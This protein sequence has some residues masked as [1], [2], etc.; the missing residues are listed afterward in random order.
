MP[1]RSLNRDF[2]SA[3]ALGKY[4]GYKNVTKFGRNPAA[5]AAM[6]DVTYQSGILDWRESATTIEAISSDADDID[7]TGAGARKIMVEGLDANFNEISEEIAMNG[8]D[9]TS[10]TSASFLRVNRA[11]VSDAGVYANG[12]TGSNEGTI[13]IRVASAGAT[14]LQIG[15][16]GTIG[17]GQT[18]HAGYT[19]PAGKSV[20]LYHAWINVDGAQSASVFLWKRENA[21]DVSA[22]FSARRLQLSL[23]GLAGSTH[24][25][26]PAPL[27]FPAKTDI[28]WSCVAGGATSV[29]VN[30]CMLEVP[31]TEDEN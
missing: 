22:P 3:V 13:T 23:D 29:S 11:Y 1:R 30:F 25:D 19:V 27:R 24:L 12:N 6:E 10:A 9:P 14:L 5:S 28:W 7:T 15:L 17:L 21:D 20:L 18:E 2:L 4:P 26:L 8:T 16:E 31:A